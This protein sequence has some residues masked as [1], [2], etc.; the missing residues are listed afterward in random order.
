MKK[1]F[2][3][4]LVAISALV[5]FFAVLALFAS[6]VVILDDVHVMSTDTVHI[7]S[8]KKKSLK[9]AF[10]GDM[11]LARGVEIKMEEEGKI[12]PFKNLGDLTQGVD[13]L[14]GNFEGV[15]TQTHY[16]T[17]SMQM[18]FSIKKEYLS[19]LSEMGFDVLSLANNHSFD[20]GKESLAY[21]RSLCEEIGLKCIGSPFAPDT[22]SYT[23]VEH[24]G[25]RVGLL[26]LH[27]L[28]AD[29]DTKSLYKALLYLEQNSEVQIAYIHWGDEYK[30]VHS[31]TQE[32]L[33]HT[34]IDSG[35]DAIIGHHPHVVQDV[36]FY[37]EKPIFYS[38]GNFVFDQYFSKDVTEGLVLHTDITEDAI[39]FALIGV[40]STTTR[41]QPVRMSPLEEQALFDRILEDV[42][43]NPM[44]QRL[45]GKVKI[46]R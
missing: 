46:P 8:P 27:T 37:K 26:A 31:P 6:P 39:E 34:L 13:I 30:L 41:S 45:E 36:A 3:Y 4:T 7:E 23:V 5:L 29:Q 33:A 44:V 38:L 2:L 12:Y 32:K 35:I 11:M 20:Y 42:V 16:E 17:P 1:R 15:V 18:R 21:T 22:Y 40:E 24:D 25:I 10:V 19:L 43:E 9:M 14:V 28:F